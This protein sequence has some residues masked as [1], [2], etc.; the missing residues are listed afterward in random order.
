MKMT[1]VKNMGQ[2]FPQELPFIGPDLFI[3]D[4]CNIEIEL[5]EYICITNLTTSFHILHAILLL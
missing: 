1:L 2:R 5:I 3:I 4:C